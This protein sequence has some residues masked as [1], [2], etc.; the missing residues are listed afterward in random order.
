[1]LNLAPYY[2]KDAMHMATHAV[3]ADRYKACSTQM[4]TFATQSK[5]RARLGKTSHL[6]HLTGMSLLRLF[7]VCTLASTVTSLLQVS[8][9]SPPSLLPAR[10]SSPGWESLGQSRLSPPSLGRPPARRMVNKWEVH[11]P[12]CSLSSAVQSELCEDM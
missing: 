5:Q 6:G 1:M 10:Q 2:R 12:E 9:H 3:W 7:C 4:A 8:N 11:V